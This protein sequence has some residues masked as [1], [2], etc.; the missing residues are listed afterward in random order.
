MGHE[1]ALAAGQ[2]LAEFRRHD[3]GGRGSQ[4]GVAGRGGVE[5]GK[6]PPLVLDPL[7]A[8]L[9]HEIDAFDRFGEGHR[10]RYARRRARRI[11]HDLIGGEL[12]EPLA[13]EPRRGLERCRARIGEPHV[14]PAAGEHEGP[15]TADQA[16]ARDGDS[17]HCLPPSKGMANCE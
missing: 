15:G 14:P 2:V 13:D 17:G 11:V 12:V 8:V 3:R 4:D 10:D 1:A 5:L 6:D 7:G 16:R 9:L